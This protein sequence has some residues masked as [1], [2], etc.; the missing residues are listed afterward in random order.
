MMRERA[1][2]NYEQI[3]SRRTVRNFADTDVDLEVIKDCIRA[4][5]TAPN[6][7]NLQPWHFAVVSNPKVKSEIRI[8]AEMEERE[9]YE[10]RATDEWLEALQPFGTDASKAFSGNG[11]SS[12]RDFRTDISP[13]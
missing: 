1:T 11:A 8:Q 6:G 5:G 12:D 3:K 4:A 7:A 2:A 9:F 10:N 13:R